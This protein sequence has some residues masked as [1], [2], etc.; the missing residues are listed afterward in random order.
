M[1]ISIGVL[2][3]VAY[4]FARMNNLTMVWAAAPAGDL[5]SSGLAVFLLCRVCKKVLM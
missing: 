2:I 5:V 1:D 3:P 4:F